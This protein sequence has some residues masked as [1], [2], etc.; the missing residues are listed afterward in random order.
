MIVEET[1]LPHYALYTK[2]RRMYLRSY[3]R[4]GSCI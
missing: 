3:L 1:H 2:R 4:F